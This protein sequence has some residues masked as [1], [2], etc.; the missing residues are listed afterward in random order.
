MEDFK[1]SAHVR[2][3]LVERDIAEDWVWRVLTTPDRKRRG[4]D[5]NLHY[6]K[7]IRERGGKPLHVVVNA[8]VHPRRVVT[9]FFD[10]RAEK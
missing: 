1:F 10:R 7:R 8:D 9:V 3:M 4:P 6:L 2:D 5:G